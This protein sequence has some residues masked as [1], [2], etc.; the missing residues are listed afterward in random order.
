M[1]VQPDESTRREAPREWPR[2]RVRAL[3][4]LLAFGFRASPTQW[5]TLFAA[6]L[7]YPLA[8][9]AM[10]YSTKL[11]VDA[12]LVGHW[13]GVLFAA[14]LAATAG[15]VAGLCGLGYVQLVI[16]N[17]ERAGE[18]ID[19]QLIGLV[20]GIPGLEH[21]ERPD[22][23]DEV[24]LVRS[25]RHLLAEATNGVVLN[26]RMWVALIGSAALLFRL[27]PLLVLLPLFGLGS[28][29]TGGRANRIRKR[30]EERNAERGRLRRHLFTM[31]TTA[32]P[33][34]EVRVFG[35]ADELVARHGT[36]V[37]AMVADSA[38]AAWQRSWLE[39]AGSLCFAVGYVGSVALVL[40][41][42]LRG[43]ATPG[44]VVLAL[45]LAAQ[46][47]RAL[48]D[49]VDMASYLGRA[50][51]AAS[52]YVWLAD[53]AATAQHDRV[54]PSAAPSRLLGGIAVEGVSF[55]YP[56]TP[57]PVLRDVSLRLPAGAVVALVG[58]T[59]PARRLW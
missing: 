33:A 58:R 4:V 44:D 14:S 37:G 54:D 2:A 41:R 31:A 23:A 36:V 5:V 18:L 34:K 42:A 20:A 19:R 13:D 43:E 35:L 1:E 56:G 11:L 7:G 30:L 6:N 12:A 53:Y 57:A 52:R 21:H 29:R 46:V 22:Y 16:E 32:A 55:Q 26:L 59:A 47:N 51:T 39:V 49:V 25:Q 8:G 15:V 40:V 27:D 10:T 9:L 3:A 38:R 17:I 28:L 45:G 48:A 50:L 24:A